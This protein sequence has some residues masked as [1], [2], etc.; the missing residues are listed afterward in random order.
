MSAI[1][2]VRFCLFPIRAH[3][4]KSAVS[5]LGFCDSPDQPISKSVS[6]VLISGEF[7]GFSRF[8]TIPAITANRINPNGPAWRRAHLLRS[9]RSWV[10]QS[11]A[12]AIWSCG[13][14]RCAVIRRRQGRAHARI[15]WLSFYIAIA[16]DDPRSVTTALNRMAAP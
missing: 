2:V 5:L 11:L 12:F 14:V 7:L 6:S 13:L 4:R 8:R 9:L 15:Q 16:H 1:L 10:P 3:P